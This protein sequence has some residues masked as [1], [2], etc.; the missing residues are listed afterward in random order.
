MSRGPSVQ[1]SAETGTAGN[2][3][4]GQR[5]AAPSRPAPRGESPPAHAPTSPAA[6]QLRLRLQPDPKLSEESTFS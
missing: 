5:G 2:S 3:S 4:G 6:G 1:L